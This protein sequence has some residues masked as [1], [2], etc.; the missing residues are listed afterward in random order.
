MT[1]GQV[2]GIFVSP[3]SGQPMQGRDAVRAFAGEGLEGDRFR[4]TV[5]ASAVDQG[6]GDGRQITLVARE[7]LTEIESETG[8][9]IPADKS[10]RNII[11]AG[12]RLNELVG[13]R[14]RVGDVELEGAELCQPCA[15]MGDV[16]NADKATV[17][18]AL[19]H[20]SGLRARIISGGTI[21]TG[22]PIIAEPPSA[23]AAG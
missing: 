19:V 12:V 20:R 16:L 11:T 7:S 21:H 3:A 5:T 17:V 1:T 15:K 4:D 10:R 14:F 9:V 22:D 13:Q 2:E 8:L 6:P 18:R 23:T